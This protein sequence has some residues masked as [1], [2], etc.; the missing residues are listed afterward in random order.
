MDTETH[1]ILSVI[2]PLYNEEK[3]IDELLNR[4]LKTMH[5]ITE[6]FEIVIVDDG[7][8]DETLLKL[9][10][11]K[12]NES[13]IKIVQLSR[14][15]GHQSAFTAGLTSSVSKYYVM[16]DGDLQDPPEK[17][18]ELYNKI[19]NSEFDLINA[20]RKSKKETLIRRVLMKL[21]HFI[22]N[23][24]INTT[25]IRDTGNFS[26]FND[27]VKEAIIS[28][29]E[30]TRYMPGIRNHVGFSTDQIFYDR[31]ERYAGKAKMNLSKLFTLAFDAIF[32][33]SNFPIRFM[34]FLGVIGLVI[35][36]LGF[37]YVFIS[38]ISG[39]AP[40]GW[41]S[42]LF[43]IFL[44]SSLQITFLGILGEYVFRVY[45]EVQNRPLFIIKKI[46]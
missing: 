2:I 46:I 10:S 36:L 6:E 34:L 13:R 23:K 31:D 15:F 24:L 44:F 5:K 29:S 30:K 37:I 18:I 12:K 8:S 19:N 16:M 25:N 33:F 43:F 35:S 22:F 41:S 7:S 3:L 11:Y 39:V 28:Y 17:I 42:N 26:I 20:S 14:N 4:L 27:Y 45:K 21:F 32:S 40:F 38:K 1:T 9:I